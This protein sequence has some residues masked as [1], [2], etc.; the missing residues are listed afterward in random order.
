MTNLTNRFAVLG[1]LVMMGVLSGCGTTQ[2][3]QEPM[4]IGGSKADG[5]VVMGA[6]VG[7]SGTVNWERADTTAL[8]R[9][10]AWGYADAE[11]FSGVR[12]RCIR[13]GW[14]GC[15]KMELSRT[16]QCLD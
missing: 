1:F 12:E 8:M 16:Y 11:P 6:N 3:P 14:S 7:K 15:A 9:C 5:T 2:K 13:D 10:R 4:D